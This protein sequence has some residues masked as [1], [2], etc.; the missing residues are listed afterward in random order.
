M[1]ETAPPDNEHPPA[2]TPAEGEPPLPPRALWGGR[3]FV[4]ALG[5]LM[6]INLLWMVRMC[7]QPEKGRRGKAAPDFQVRRLDGGNF[8]LSESQGHPVLVDFWATWCIPC[9]QSLPILDKV[10]STYKDRG[11]QAIAIE[12]EGNEGPA[13]AMARQLGLKMPVGLGDEE[14]SRVYGIESIPHLVLV[15]SQG[16]IARVFHGVHDFNELS[17]AVEGAGLPQK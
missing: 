4:S 14:V 16:E 2:P 7:G 12:T 1:N 3:L 10:Y 11:L 5:L 17:R 13:R 6:V 9:R 8:R 15:N